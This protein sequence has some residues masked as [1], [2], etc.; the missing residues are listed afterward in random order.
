MVRCAVRNRKYQCIMHGG[1]CR[2][3]GLS[4]KLCLGFSKSC[5][6]GNRA[7]RGE[8]RGWKPRLPGAKR[9]VGNRAYWEEGNEK[10]SCGEQVRELI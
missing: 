6:V 1:I 3:V 5:A 4:G 8:A 7:Y 2:A 9:A 10:S